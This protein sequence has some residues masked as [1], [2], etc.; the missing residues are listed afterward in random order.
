MSKIGM[1]LYF[2]CFNPI[3][4]RILLN[5]SGVDDIDNIG[6]EATELMGQID[7][8]GSGKIDRAEWREKWVSMQKALG[9][10]R[11]SDNLK[12]KLAVKVVNL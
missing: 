5:L 9:K 4:I 7:A 12:Q 2:Y 6:S 10:F 11:P 3:L 8:D 1:L